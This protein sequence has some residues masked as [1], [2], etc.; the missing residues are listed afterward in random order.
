MYHLFGYPIEETYRSLQEIPKAIKTAPEAK[1]L[2]YKEKIAPMDV[3][4]LEE[5]RKRGDLITSL[6]FLN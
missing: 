2:S 5:I 4:T 1:Q 3:P 6:R